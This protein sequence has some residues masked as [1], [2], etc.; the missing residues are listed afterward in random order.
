MSVYY[1]N[2]IP[3]AKTYHTGLSECFEVDGC[4]KKVAVCVVEAPRDVKGAAIGREHPRGD[5]GHDPP[6]KILKFVTSKTQSGTFWR[7]KCDFS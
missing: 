3:Q 6:W 4:R 7:G 1:K 5:R 2:Q